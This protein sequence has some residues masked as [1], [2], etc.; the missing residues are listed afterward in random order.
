MP[1]ALL[2]RCFLARIRAG[3]A[4]GLG[5]LLL[6]LAAGPSVGAGFL[7]KEVSFSEAEVQARIDRSAPQERRYGD[8]LTVAL[9]APPRVTLGAPVADRVGLTARAEVSVLGQPSVPVDL[10]ATAGIRYDDASKA[11]YLENPLVERVD[12]PGLPPEA[13]VAVR[14]ALGHGLAAYYRSRPIHV[15]RADGSPQEASARWLLRSIRIEP[16]RVVAVLSPF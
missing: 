5:A 9:Q 4:T 13:K 3:F 7:E 14:R 11:F 12:A 2:R 8:L 1:D 16:G 15:L 10:E 6:A